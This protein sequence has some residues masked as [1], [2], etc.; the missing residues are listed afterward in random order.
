MNDD[1][2]PNTGCEMTDRLINLA[3]EAWYELLKDKMKQQIQSSCGE[4]LDG[5]AEFVTNANNER[6]THMITGKAK[7]EQFK[8]GLAEMMIAG[9]S[10]E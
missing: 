9:A 6:W 10:E 7:C 4:K 1:M 2:N 5:L 3:D 8:Q